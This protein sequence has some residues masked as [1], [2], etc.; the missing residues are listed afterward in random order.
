MKDV[1]DA[2]AAQG[3]TAMP[4][5]PAQFSQT[6]AADYKKWRGV[7]QSANVKLE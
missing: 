3:A 7:I 2:L 5:T 4:T 1:Q 6:I